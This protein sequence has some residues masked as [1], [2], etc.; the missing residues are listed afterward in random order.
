MK[1]LITL[2]MVVLLA[3]CDTMYA[4]HG[5]Q[6]YRPAYGGAAVYVPMPMPMYAA[7][8]MRNH[9]V[10]SNPYIQPTNHITC[11]QSGVF[12]NCF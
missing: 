7:P 2:F 12:T 6:N 11:A 8:M 9:G 10:N 1:T 5:Q 3:G 4:N